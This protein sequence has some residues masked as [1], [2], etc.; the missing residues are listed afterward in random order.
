MNTKELSFSVTFIFGIPR[1]P[2]EW[3]GNT[4]SDFHSLS[5]V[6]VD[7]VKI[8]CSGNWPFLSFRRCHSLK[9]VLTY[10]NAWKLYQLQYSEGLSSY[11]KLCYAKSNI[12][13]SNISAVLCIVR[14]PAPLVSWGTWLCY[15]QLDSWPISKGERVGDA[16][17]T[18]DICGP[19]LP[20][21][22]TN[23]TINI[24]GILWRK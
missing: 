17:P 9:C 24:V 12:I 13:R 3:V 2:C 11:V 22:C 8:P 14:F 15:T 1:W 21:Q 5:E 20:L 4:I 18:M 6:P 23:S 7:L 16:H 10:C 19:S